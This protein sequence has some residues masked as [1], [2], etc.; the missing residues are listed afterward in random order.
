MGKYTHIFTKMHTQKKLICHF[1]SKRT[2]KTTYITP[3]NPSV[4]NDTNMFSV[5]S[6][7]QPHGYVY[8]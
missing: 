4:M 8:F 1:F 6:R 7:T 2:K 3:G 5:S